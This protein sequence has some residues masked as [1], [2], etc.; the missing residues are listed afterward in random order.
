MAA[1]SE[2]RRP[3]RLSQSGKLLALLERDRRWWSTAELLREVPCI[4]HSRVAEIRKYGWNVEH[5]TTGPGA[6]GSEYRLA[7]DEPSPVVTSDGSCPPREGSSSAAGLEPVAEQEPLWG[8]S[9]AGRDG[10][11]STSSVPVAL[12]LT[13]VCVSNV[14]FRLFDP[15][16]LQEC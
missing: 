9:P 11:C 12:E 15:V 4:V 2:R 8:G 10:A 14:P 13:T 6:R 3:S 5:R 1:W 16:L 7:L